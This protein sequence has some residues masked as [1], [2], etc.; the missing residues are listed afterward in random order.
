MYIDEPPA[1]PSG[2]AG[3]RAAARCP[4]QAA[5]GCNCCATDRALEIT[6]CHVAGHA[7]SAYYFNE[8]PNEISLDE[9][10]GKNTWI[11]RAL[12]PT[13]EAVIASASSF[14]VGHC[15]AG[16]CNPSSFCADRQ[17]DEASCRTVTG[18][19]PTE[20]AGQA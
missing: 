11:D 12:D 18:S 6:A 3:D 5:S 10:S 4:N 19:G 15:P 16:K 13:H 14:A 1:D 9:G 2:A 8:L 20:L 7:I 17:V